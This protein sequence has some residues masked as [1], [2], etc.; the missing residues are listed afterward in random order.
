M[1]QNISC[2]KIIIIIFLK[3]QICIII[4]IRTI[5]YQMQTYLMCRIPW[6]SLKQNKVFK[7]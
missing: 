2:V 1:F 4:V 5:T 6:M 7:A 3:T